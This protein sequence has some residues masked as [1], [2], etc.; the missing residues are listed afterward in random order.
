[1]LATDLRIQLMDSAGKPVWRKPARNR[2]GFEEG[3]LSNRMVTG[4]TWIDDELWHGTWEGDESDVRRVDPQ[5]GRVLEKFEMPSGMGVSGLESDGGDRFYC[6]GGSS[7]TVRAVRRP[8]Q[9][10][11]RAADP[12]IPFDTRK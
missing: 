2:I 3:V 11:R 4:V 6:G 1:V 7:G 5:T 10:L 8:G 9:A 12:G